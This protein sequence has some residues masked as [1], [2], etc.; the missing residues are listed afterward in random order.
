MNV[1]FTRLAYIFFFIQSIVWFVQV[2]IFCPV[3]FWEE[4]TGTFLCVTGLKIWHFNFF[5]LPFAGMTSLKLPKKR[6]LLSFP[7]QYRLVIYLHRLLK[8]IFLTDSKCGFKNGSWVNFLRL[9]RFGDLSYNFPII[10][11]FEN[12]I[13]NLSKLKIKLNRMEMPHAIQI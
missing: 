13:D 3:T 10:N 1:K 6:W 2:F 7:T 9:W 8:L 4:N 12:P 5:R 11:C